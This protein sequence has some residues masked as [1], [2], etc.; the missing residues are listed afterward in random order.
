MCKVL[1]CTYDFNSASAAGYAVEGTSCGDGKWC[2]RGECVADASAPKGQ[3]LVEDDTAFCNDFL[4]KY[5]MLNVCNNFKTGRCCKMCGGSSIPRLSGHDWPT[6]L[7]GNGL[8]NVK[9][10]DQVYVS[11]CVDKYTWCPTNVA[12]WIKS[13]PNICGGSYTVNEEPINVVCKKSCNLC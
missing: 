2:V 13:I 3:C 6:F 11:P 5:G 7:N 1:W 10:L 12:N 8:D 9:F 4:S